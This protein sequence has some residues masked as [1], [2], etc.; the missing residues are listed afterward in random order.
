MRETAAQIFQSL[1]GQKQEGFHA[2]LAFDIKNVGH[3]RLYVK[4]GRVQIDH[5]NKKADFTMAATEEE[6]EKIIEGRQNLLTAIMQ[7]R[8]KFKGDIILGQKFNAAL[9]SNIKRIRRK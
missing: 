3:W 2:V 8:V 1:Q 9:R 5:S 4:D 7:G 6:F